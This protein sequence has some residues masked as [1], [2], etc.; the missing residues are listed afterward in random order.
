M[1]DVA[2]ELY[3]MLKS[4]RNETEECFNTINNDGVYALLTESFE[5]VEPNYA[6]SNTMLFH[7]I[8]RNFSKC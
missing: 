7:Y 8:T 5:A 4:I 6:E 3:I 1:T 2:L